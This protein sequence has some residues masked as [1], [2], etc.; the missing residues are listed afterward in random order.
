M[1]EFFASGRVIDLIIVLV[2]VECLA[3]WLYRRMTGQGPQLRALFPTILAGLGLMLALRS[4]LIGAQHWAWIAAPLVVALLAHLW[5]L[6]L[7]W[8]E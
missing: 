2:A 8:R 7:R 4:A 3:L 1:G 6:A 5:D